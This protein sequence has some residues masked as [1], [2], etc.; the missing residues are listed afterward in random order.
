MAGIVSATLAK[1]KQRAIAFTRTSFD[2]AYP[3]GPRRFLG[4]LARALALLLW[5]LQKSLEDLSKDIVPSSES[6]TDA[7]SAWAALLGLPDG[8]GGYGRRKA[9]AASGG[10]ATL[11]GEKGTFYPA[12]TTA[13]AEDGTTQIELVDDVTIPGSG[14]GS[15][16]ATGEFVAVEAGSSGNLEVGTVCTWESAPTGADPTFTLTSALDDGEDLEDNPTVYARIV[17]RLQNPP[18]G[19]AAADYRF[20]ATVSSVLSVYVYPKRSGTGT[21]D[22]VIVEGGSG[23][24]RIPAESVRLE[25]EATIE[26]AMPVDVEDVNVLVPNMPNSEGLAV[27]LRVTSSKSDYDFDFDD[28]GTAMAVGSYT[29]GP[30][31]QIVLSGLAPDALK[32]AIDAYIA[33]PNTVSAPRLQVV[34]TGVAINEPIRAV[35]WSDGG[36]NTTLTLESVPDN[37]ESPTAADKIY[38]YGPVVATIAAGVVALCD[39]LGPSNVSGF[40]DPRQPWEDSLTISGIKAVAENAIDTDGTKLIGKV[41]VGGATID[42]AEADVQPD[43]STTDGPKMLYLKSVAVTA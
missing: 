19:G 29:A 23:Q 22:V 14:S 34:S 30:P 9:R 1:W 15:G 25:A 24:G 20:W 2:G 16:S 32:D 26:D 10:V 42:G 17:S 13:T 35:A 40:A 31:A 28:G 43:D 4:R 8:E 39:S 18:R 33:N 37:W 6:S 38:A 11:T 5:Q 21:V 27:R 36:G 41:L 3:L 7:L 12:G